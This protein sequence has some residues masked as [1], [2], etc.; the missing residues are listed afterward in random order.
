M[1]TSL[2]AL[3]AAATLVATGASAADL[4]GNCYAD[5][6]ERIAELEATTARKGNRKVKLTVSGW[7]HEQVMYWDDGG[8]RNTYVFTGPAPTRFRFVGEA[9]AVLVL[10]VEVDVV[11]GHDRG[12]VRA[13]ALTPT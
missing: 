6:E 2:F 7:V 10:M 11:T 13:V 4:G 9:Q 5:L 1:K 8:E 3:A 12:D